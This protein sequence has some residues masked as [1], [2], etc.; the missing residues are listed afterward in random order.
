[1]RETRKVMASHMSAPDPEN[2]V[3]RRASDLINK[4]SE[5]DQQLLDTNKL[6]VSLGL[7]TPPILEKYKSSFKF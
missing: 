3:K 7:M 2:P 1:M 5:G 6:A 4:L